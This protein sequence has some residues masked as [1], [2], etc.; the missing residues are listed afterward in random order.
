M[1]GLIW[2]VSHGK[3]Q[4][5]TLVYNTLIMRKGVKTGFSM[6]RP[7]TAFSTSAK[8]HFTGGKVDDGIIDTSAAEAALRSDLPDSRFLPCKEV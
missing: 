6:V 8:P 2:L 3:I 7:H 5:G 4:P 1:D